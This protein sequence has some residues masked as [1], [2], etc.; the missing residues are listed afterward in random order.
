MSH[1][2]R[3]LAAVAAGNLATFGAWCESMADDDTQSAEDRALWTELAYL[4]ADH[5]K[6]RTTP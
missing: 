6:G 3:D 2:P 4:I 1:R 5:L